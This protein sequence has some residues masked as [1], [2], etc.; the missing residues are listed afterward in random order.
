MKNKDG[1]RVRV[2]DPGYLGCVLI[3]SED[4]KTTIDQMV[5][6]FKVEPPD[7]YMARA[8]AYRPKAGNME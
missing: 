7:D 1:P 2:T 4:E 3:T 6:E 5:S 8:R